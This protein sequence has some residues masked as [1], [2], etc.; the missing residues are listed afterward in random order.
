VRDAVLELN[1]E[2]GGDRKFILVQ[3]A[4]DTKENEKE[5]FK[6]CEK[7]TAERVRRVIKGYS[8]STQRRKEAK[9]QSKTSSPRLR[10]LAT[11]R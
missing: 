6:I 1:K 2:D 4:F 8:Y 9:T 10:A 5:K 11:L 3:Q 7:I